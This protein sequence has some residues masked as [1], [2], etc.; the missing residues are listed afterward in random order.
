M[1]EAA[2]HIVPPLPPR[3]VL[4]NDSSVARGGATGLTLLLARQL[5]AR[6][7]DVTLICGDEG[8]EGRL[9]AEGITLVPLG[10]R[11]LL[12]DGRLRAMRRGIYDPV[13]RDRIAS[14][15]A[16]T[17]TPDTVYHLHGWSRI[18]SP[19]V[20]DALRPVA[21]RCYIHAHDF[22]L[23]CPNE[24]YF[25][26]PRRLTCRR[27]PLSAACIATQCDKRSYAQK[28]WRVARQAAVRRAFTPDAN[29]AG[30]LMLHDGMAEGLTRAGVPRDL[31]QTVRNPAR[32]LTRARIRAEENARFCYI[33]RIEVGK[34]V[35][36]L[37][38]AARHSG[39]ALKV[40]GDDSA[41]PH[42]RAAFPE[43]VFTGWV[44]QSR[45]GALLSDVR[46][47]VMPSRYPEPFGLV[48]AEASL[49]GLPVVISDAAL[50]S[51]EL[52][53]NGLGLAAD[54]SSVDGL[55]TALHR[56][57]QM[58]A[59]SVREISERGFSGEAALCQS[60]DGWASQIAQLYERSVGHAAS[61]SS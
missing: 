24:V 21:Q 35:E 3:V 14:F 44:D 4:L 26:Y 18:L 36:T 53:R 45:I 38:H 54:T 11:L 43:V 29:W 2:T 17:D 1:H 37:C 49:S 27:V 47:L 51:G 34:G 6:G 10:G 7:T 8:D 28:L 60:Q 42:L 31:L 58:S 48:A 22:F 56:M 30:V 32:A 39:V 23:A 12:E 59:D 9:A 50:L 55:A 57:A 46:A 19:S 20:F 5:Q 40:I 41:R 61:Q 13:T 25:D 16:R 15:I 33:G 52:C